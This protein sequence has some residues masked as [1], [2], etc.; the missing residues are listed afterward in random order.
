M[1][2]AT[3]PLESAI[4]DPEPLLDTPEL[5]GS[6]ISCIS[7]H[8]LNGLLV[9]STLKLAGTIHSKKVIVLID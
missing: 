6:K 5:S 2:D 3:A 4:I 9:P 8:A 7:F 1:A